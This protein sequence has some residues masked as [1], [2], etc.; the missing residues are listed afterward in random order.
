MSKAYEN[1]EILQKLIRCNEH[2]WLICADL[3]V[4]ALILGL[5]GL[6]GGHNKFPCFLCLWDSRADASHFTRKLWPSRDEF[7]P[8]SKNVKAHPLVAPAKV[9]L[10]P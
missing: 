3:K 6:Q 7:L 9:L 4:V 2:N 8:G 1:I 10:P 5:Q